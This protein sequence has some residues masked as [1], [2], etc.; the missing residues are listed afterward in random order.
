M[1]IT[2]ISPFSLS[3]VMLLLLIWS[4][5]QFCYV[6]GRWLNIKYPCPFQFKGFKPVMTRATFQFFFLLVRC[7]CTFSNS[8]QIPPVRLIIQNKWK[9]D[10]KS[11]DV[12]VFTAF[13]LNLRYGLF[14]TILISSPNSM[15]FFYLCSQTNLKQIF[16][17]RQC[18]WW[19]RTIR[20]DVA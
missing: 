12:V 7:H 18:C 20:T 1:Y 14:G 2:R 15:H 3:L 16:L 5:V 17:V 6:K 11:N 13:K 8:A 9:F 4:W 19:L 10:N